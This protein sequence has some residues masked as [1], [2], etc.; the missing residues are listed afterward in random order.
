MANVAKQQTFVTN[1]GPNMKEFIARM[2]PLWNSSVTDPVTSAVVKIAD[3]PNLGYGIG[4]GPANPNPA[5]QTF[6]QALDINVLVPWGSQLATEGAASAEQREWR[7]NLV[8]NYTF[9]K[10]SAVPVF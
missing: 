10:N 5:A 6:G 9:G 1:V 2:T 7:A 3:I 4:F 8:T